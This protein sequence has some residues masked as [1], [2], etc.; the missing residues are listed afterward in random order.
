VDDPGRSFPPNRPEVLVV[1][2]DP[3]VLR[4]LDLALRHYGFAVRQARG[5]EQAVEIYQ[6][7][8][9]S[10]ALV[11]MDVQMPGLDGPQTF[12][13]L[14]A[15]DPDMRC[16]FLSGDPGRYSPEELLDLGAVH[17]F[18]KPF[19]NLREHMAILQGLASSQNPDWRTAGR[20]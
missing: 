17:V 12:A 6:R 19:I 8:R 4:F 20:G 18:R 15:L 14:R 11:L 13:R 3:D 1:D 7:H 5:G 2:D 16:C 10:I 9:G